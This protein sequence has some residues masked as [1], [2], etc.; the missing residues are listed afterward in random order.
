MICLAS[1]AYLLIPPA[2]PPCSN[3]LNVIWS[4]QSA[5]PSTFVSS[6]LR[7]SAAFSLRSDL[8]RAVAVYLAE[9]SGPSTSVAALLTQTTVVPAAANL[10]C[11]LSSPA[12]S[13]N[14]LMSSLR[15]FTDAGG[16]ALVAMDMAAC[17][18]RPH[19]AALSCRVNQIYVIGNALYAYVGTAAELG[20]VAVDEP[21]VA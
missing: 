17:F 21:C 1:F 7:N 13:G 3:T 9:A 19:G 20:M 10:T 16:V 18:A 4:A 14:N 11:P 6:G 15:L 8:A 12:G 5:T 2:P